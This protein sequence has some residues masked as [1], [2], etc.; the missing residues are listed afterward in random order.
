MP[1]R[2]GGRLREPRADCE[3][4]ETSSMATGGGC[5][6]PIQSS[7]RPE[8][9]DFLGFYQFSNAGIVHSAPVLILPSNKDGFAVTRVAK[10]W[11][12]NTANPDLPN[13]GPRVASSCDVAH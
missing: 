8:P 4:N 12:R 13:F 2:I 11:P 5:R 7:L 3:I 6:T 10:Y 9:L 1:A